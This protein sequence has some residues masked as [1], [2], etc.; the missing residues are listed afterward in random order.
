MIC[1]D[2]MYEW[3]WDVRRKTNPTEHVIC[4]ATFLLIQT[5]GVEY[6]MLAG[7]G[8]YWL[9][10]KLGLDVDAAEDSLEIP[11]QK[12]PQKELASYGAI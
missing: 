6:G 7:V 11:L 1:M 4:I 2:L 12:P 10:G 3:L 9:C 5:L 8:V